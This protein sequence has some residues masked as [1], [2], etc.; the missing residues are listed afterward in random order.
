MQRGATASGERPW[1]QR[2]LNESPSCAVRS[3]RSCGRRAAGCSHTRLPRSPSPKVRD[4]D[5]SCSPEAR[6]E[7]GDNATSRRVQ[8]GWR[9]KEAKNGQPAG[10]WPRKIR[11]STAAANPTTCWLVQQGEGR[12]FGV[13]HPKPCQLCLANRTLMMMVAMGGACDWV[14]I[15]PAEQA[16]QRKLAAVFWLVIL[17]A[18]EVGAACLSTVPVLASRTFLLRP[19]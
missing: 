12:R 7:W 2:S 6:Y 13:S 18:F 3:G 15:K 16:L 17:G 10:E 11:H 14:E 5:R 1:A 19:S 4:V 8:T 9:G